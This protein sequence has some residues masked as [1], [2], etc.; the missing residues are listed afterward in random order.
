MALFLATFVNKIDKK[1]RIS[2]PATFRASLAGE[3]FQGI[4]AF[5]SYKH[6]AIDCCGISRMEKLSSHVDDMDVFS[7][8]Q[9]DMS[10]MIFADSRQLA[11][12]GDGRIVIPS[13][14]LK[15]AG[16]SE[17]AAFVGRGPTFQIWNPADFE[18]LQDHTRARVFE[19][20]DVV[21]LKS[22]ES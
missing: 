10:A 9:D 16:I 12:D 14:F 8:R 5:R 11:L 13:E 6:Q 15:H 18:R 21:Q 20:K 7:D 4:V 19:Q 2:V 17:E 22:I 1:G 3:S